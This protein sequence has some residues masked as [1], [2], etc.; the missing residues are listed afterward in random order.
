M[1]RSVLR[2]F[3][4]TVISLRVTMYVIDAF[5]FGDSPEKSFVLVVLALSLLYY[6]LKPILAVVSLPR[7]GVGFLFLSFVMTLVILQVLTLFIPSFSITETELADLIV[8]GFVLP[9]K[10][11]TGLWSG[12]FSALLLSLIFV[13]FDWLCD[14]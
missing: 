1:I 2:A 13:F 11:L 3:V 12:V 5:S 4:F 10:S 8:F 6:F 9:S 14:R 7:K